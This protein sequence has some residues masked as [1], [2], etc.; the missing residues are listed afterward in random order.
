MLSAESIEDIRVQAMTGQPSAFKDI[1]K[2]Y[3]LTVQEVAK[4]G[5]NTYNRYLGILIT[6]EMSIAETIKKKT[7]ETVPLENI[8]P[9]EYL[10]TSANLNDM[11]LLELQESFSTF[12]KEEVLLLPKI[13]AV[14]IGNPTDRRLITE[15]NFRDFQDILRLQNDREVTEPPPENET[16]GQRKMRL[17]REQVAAVKRKQAQKNGE[18][19]SFDELIE[20]AETF[21]IDTE[22][23]LYAYYKLL[24]RHKL[25]EKWDQDIKMLCAGADSSKIKTQYWG[26]SL[27]E[28]GG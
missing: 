23:S 22:H 15:K 28:T 13:N 25:K 11:F 5:Y 4:I 20:I 19:Q 21:G 27:K 24:R 14:A 16:P 17:R 8:R 3:P 26:E 10:L 6:D 7:Q 9:L 1:C 2:V 18:K 12:I